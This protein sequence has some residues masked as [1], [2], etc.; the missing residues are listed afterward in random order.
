MITLTWEAHPVSAMKICLVGCR[1]PFSSSAMRSIDEVEED[2]CPTTTGLFGKRE[3]A[4]ELLVM[5]GICV[6]PMEDGALLCFVLLSDI[7]VPS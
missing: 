7:T 2:L 3:R 6:L 1:L 5:S 4:L